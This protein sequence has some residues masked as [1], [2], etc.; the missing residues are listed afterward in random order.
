M[1]KFD[2]QLVYNLLFL[3]NQMYFNDISLY[4]VFLLHM[5]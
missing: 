1:Y 4:F 3:Y 2:F 5:C